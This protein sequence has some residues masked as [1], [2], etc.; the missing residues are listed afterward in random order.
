MAVKNQQGMKRTTGRT[1]L[2]SVFDI[3][4]GNYNHLN[5]SSLEIAYSVNLGVQRRLTAASET[6]VENM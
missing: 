3:H 6:M 1:I 2:L 5:A 4:I